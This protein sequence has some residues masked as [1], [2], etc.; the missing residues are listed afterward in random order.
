MMFL[1]LIVIALIVGAIGVLY[2]VARALGR[3]IERRLES[4][5]GAAGV[6]DGA[7]LLPILRRIEERIDA[8][9]SE[10]GRM[11]EHQEFMDALLENREPPRLGEPEPEDDA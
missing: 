9:E 11:R 10:Q 4:G 2:P 3:A 8:L 5:G 1:N 7:D 6:G